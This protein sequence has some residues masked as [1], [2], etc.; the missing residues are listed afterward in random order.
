MLGRQAMR[1]SSRPNILTTYSSSSYYYYYYCLQLAHLG[2]AHS[3]GRPACLGLGLGLDLGLGLGL[4]PGL[5]LV[6]V[7]GPGL[8][9]GWGP[10]CEK[11]KRGRVCSPT[12]Y[13]LVWVRVRV[14]G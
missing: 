11:P 8:G 9:L 3:L 5:G 10:R 1:H 2:K 6:L 4:G 13:V 7:L 12:A 14:K